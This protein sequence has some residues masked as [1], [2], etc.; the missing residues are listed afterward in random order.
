MVM[1]EEDGFDDILDI[2]EKKIASAGKFFKGAILD[3][4]YRGKTLN[5][6]EE[7]RL[8]NL[9]SQKSGAIIKS[10]GQDTEDLYAV[11][12]E[13]PVES[14]VKLKVKNFFYKG[15]DEGVTKFYKGTVRSGQLIDFEGN[16]VVIGDVNPGGVIEAAGNVII[17]GT[18]RG[19]VHAGCDGNRDAVVVALNLQPTQLRIADLITRA[20]DEADVRTGFIPEI[21]LIRDDMVYIERYL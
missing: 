1:R 10:I 6:Q 4:K 2:I 16:V 17:M 13:E 14:Q 8:F 21:A 11:Q 12:Q 5:R 3:V 19:I 15:I 18:L 20:P 9:M 7:T